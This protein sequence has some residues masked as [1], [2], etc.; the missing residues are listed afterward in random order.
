MRY[1]RH[2]EGTLVYRVVRD[3]I[4]EYLGMLKAVGIGAGF[5][6]KAFRS[7][8]GCG[9]PEKG[10]Y[11]VVQCKKCGHEEWVAFTCKQTGVCPWCAKQKMNADAKELVERV[12]PAET[13]LH[14]VISYPLWANQKLAFQPRVLSKVERTVMGMLARWQEKRNMKTGGGAL[15]RHRF[16]GDL[17]MV[18]HD[19][20]LLLGGGFRCVPEKRNEVTGQVE[21]WKGVEASQEEIEALARQLWKRVKKVLEKAGITKPAK[22]EE[23][24]E[25]EPEQVELFVS[26]GAVKARATAAVG[27]KDYDEVEEP[28]GGMWARVEGLH[29]YA[30]EPIDGNDRPNLERLCQYL[31]RPAWDPARLGQ[32]SDG[33][34]TYRLKKKDKDGNT[35][36]VMTPTEFL[37]RLMSLMTAPRQR[38]RKLFGILGPR[39]AKRKEVL[40]RGQDD[41]KHIAKQEKAISVA[42]A[43]D[44]SKLREV[45]ERTWAP[46]ER[47]C[48]H[49]GKG[50]MV[51]VR[52]VLPGGSALGTELLRERGP[53]GESSAG[54]S[55]V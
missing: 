22:K 45:V 7:Y 4:D 1:E 46:D 36:L 30:S 6:E 13:Y 51:L 5:I 15:F 2:P 41:C 52:V 40:P 35:V 9:I 26:A 21:V 48:P 3:H 23:K 33:K 10:G 49:C 28:R 47:K 11:A 38:T 54:R 14:M 43:R 19:H 8:L 12:L 37:R 29:V 16:G 32:R 55:I 20:I 50:T 53:P 27:A 42:E 25:S 44:Y 18:I 31:L 17:E 24:K 39:A 34:L